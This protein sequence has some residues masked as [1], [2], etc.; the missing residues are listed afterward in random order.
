MSFIG[1][2]FW[3]IFIGLW[4][5]LGWIL[6]GVICCITIVGIP[7]GKQCFKMAGLTFLPLWQGGR[8]RRRHG[9]LPGKHPV[10]HLP[11]LGAGAVL[12]GDG[13]DL[14]R[15][16]RGDPSGLA[17]LQNG[18]AGPDALRRGGP[19]T[20]RKQYAARGRIKSPAGYF[21]QKRV[22]LACGAPFL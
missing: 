18:K 11:G 9:Q 14:L 22:R 2:V 5:G 4:S 21:C 1:N 6:S 15:H 10:D 3:F 13:A 16:H 20:R 7:L 12:C 19:V 17:E 8:I